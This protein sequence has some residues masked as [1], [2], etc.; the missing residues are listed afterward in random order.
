MDFIIKCQSGDVEQVAG[1]NILARPGT[2][3]YLILHI[4]DRGR[5]VYTAPADRIDIQDCGNTLAVTLGTA[6]YQPAAK[7]WHRDN[8]LPPAA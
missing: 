3:N 4:L 7:P 2:K 6:K 5:V 8:E 1:T